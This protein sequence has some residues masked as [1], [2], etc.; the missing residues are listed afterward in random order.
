VTLTRADIDRFITDGF[1]RL[2]GAVDAAVAAACREQLWDATGYDADDPSTWADT[3][4]RLDGLSTPPFRA[5]AN[6]PMLLA[7][8]DQLVGPGRWVPRTGLGTFPLRFPGTGEAKEAGWHV[9]ASY[10][11]ADGEWRVNLRSRGRALLMLF[12]FSDVGDRDAPTLIRVGSHHDVGPVLAP[13]GDDGLEWAT[14]CERVVAASASRPVTSAVGSL[15]DVY[16]CH[17][18]LV[19]SAQPHQGTMPRFMAQPPLEPTGLLDLN[20][21]TPFP[22]EQAV[23]MSLKRGARGTAP[24]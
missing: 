7:A 11:G 15:G 17:P 3:L 1:V 5:A 4:V 19:H 23:A 21:A 2:D 12:L 18:F 8:F 22:V 10:A 6:S 9:E 14:L 13:F 16:L 24:A 20:R